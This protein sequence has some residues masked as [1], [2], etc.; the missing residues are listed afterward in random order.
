[1]T[2]DADKSRSRDE[3]C[4]RGHRQ[5]GAD[6]DARLQAWA[7]LSEAANAF[8]EA[9]DTWHDPDVADE[10]PRI[11]A[12][13]PTDA[14]DRNDGRHVTT[15]MVRQAHLAAERAILAALEALSRTVELSVTFMAERAP[16]PGSSGG[17]SG[18]LIARCSPGEVAVYHAYAHNMS[19]HR[20]ESI[21]LSMGELRSPAGDILEATTTF[22]P[23]CSEPIEAGETA[24]FS[25]AVLVDEN[26][27]PTDYFGLLFVNGMSSQPQLVTLQVHG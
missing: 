4:D 23:E 12:D 1:M 27:I 15:Q 26:A 19:H 3:E 8:V 25:I 5:T 13:Q 20:Y 6:G 9:S 16:E 2:I 14:D 11:Q 7:V 22:V 21:R 24:A 10:G 17:P 18:E